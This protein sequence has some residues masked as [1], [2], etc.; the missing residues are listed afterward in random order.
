[1]LAAPARL[2]KLVAR[3]PA[4]CLRP[5]LSDALSSWGGPKESRPVL[6]SMVLASSGGYLRLACHARHWAERPPA[7]R[8]KPNS[9]E[10]QHEPQRTIPSAWPPPHACNAKTTYGGMPNAA[11]V[12]CDYCPF[13]R[14]DAIA[15]LGRAIKCQILLSGGRPSRRSERCRN[16]H[17]PGD[18]DASQPRSS[19]Q[20]GVQ[21]LV[22][23]HREV[24]VVGM[25]PVPTCREARSAIQRRRHICRTPRR[26]LA[27]TG[28]PRTPAAVSREAGRL[29]R[30]CKETR[31]SG[32]CSPG[33]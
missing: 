13:N 24:A 15:L 10:A 16:A 20:R 30:E 33:A 12:P 21:W 1:M 28:R 8:W 18:T 25:P 2:E 6:T 29:I 17:G 22:W 5:A 9:P 3:A 23:L 31:A 4:R 14:C 19:R 7:Y 32:P 27:A 11:I 26:V